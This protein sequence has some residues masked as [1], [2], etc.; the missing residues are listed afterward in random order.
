LQ[1]LKQ[2][3]QQ[4]IHWQ[5]VIHHA[6]R[7]RQLLGENLEHLSFADRQTVAEG[8]VKKV[9][10]GEHRLRLADLKRLYACIP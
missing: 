7:F 8:L 6:K 1:Q 10:T 9:V 2:R 5:Q 4:A 3:Q